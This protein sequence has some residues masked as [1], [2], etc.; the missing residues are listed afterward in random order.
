MV[1]TLQANHVHA[2]AGDY[3]TELIR[4]C[5]MLNIEPVALGD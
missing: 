3:C 2:V 1:Q 4:L 5:H